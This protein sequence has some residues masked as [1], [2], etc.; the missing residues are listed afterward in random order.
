LKTG[1]LTY[2]RSIMERES[3]Q[4]QLEKFLLE[5]SSKAIVKIIN[6]S[7]HAFH[8][9]ESF[10][11]DS[12]VKALEKL[13]CFTSARD[14]IEGIQFVSGELMEN[15]HYFQIQAW[16]SSEIL[17][18]FQSYRHSL[19]HSEWFIF[20]PVLGHETLDEIELRKQREDPSALVY[21]GPAVN[22]VRIRSLESS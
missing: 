4:V 18:S 9:Q 20:L 19:L 12:N 16:F 17:R 10:S 11:Q 8:I 13:V 3:V 1:D 22:R 6:L 21:R 15:R 2:L 7:I 14:S 5:V